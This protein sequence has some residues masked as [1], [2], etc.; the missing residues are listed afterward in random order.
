MPREGECWYQHDGLWVFGVPGERLEPGELHAPGY[1][2]SRRRRLCEIGDTVT[3]W[4]RHDRALRVIF[5]AEVHWDKWLFGGEWRIFGYAGT[6]W[7][8]YHGRDLRDV[9]GRQP[10]LLDLLAEVVA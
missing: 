6:A 9:E 3:V 5:V 2:A 7:R 4:D 8:N 10:D 1:T